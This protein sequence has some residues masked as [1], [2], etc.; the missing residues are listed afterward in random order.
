MLAAA[1]Q[2]RPPMMQRRRRG[3]ARSGG[4]APSAAAG[5]APTSQARCPNLF[6]RSYHHESL[7]QEPGYVALP[8]EVELGGIEGLRWV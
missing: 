5:A 8:A 3:K 6:Y 1:P 4:G 2:Q 7:R